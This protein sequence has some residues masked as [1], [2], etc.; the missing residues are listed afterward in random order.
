MARLVLGKI[1]LD[2][3]SNDVAQAW[4]KAGT[5]YTAELDG[6]IRPWFGRVWCNPPYG[7]TQPK[8]RQAKDWLDLAINRYQAGDVDAAILLLNRT[9][10]TWYRNLRKQVTAF[11]EVHERIAFLDATGK[12]QRSP[13]YHNDFLYLG[14][15][16]DLFKEIFSEIGEVR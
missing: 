14:Q 4:I 8:G 1:D 13:R 12:S 10:A 7:K 3:A 6:M 11:C 9:G 16:A 5:Y 2:P 15:K